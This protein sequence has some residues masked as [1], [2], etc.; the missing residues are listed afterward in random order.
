MKWLQW[1]KQR[2]CSHDWEYKEE[3]LYE[4]LLDCVLRQGID[5]IDCRIHPEEA[6][7]EV[8]FYYAVCRKCGKEII[9]SCGV[10]Y[11]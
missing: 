10:H 1:I 8:K 6:L 9:V 5:F 4:E 7:I 3:V 2:R 11:L